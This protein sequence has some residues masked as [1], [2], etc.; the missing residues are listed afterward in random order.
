MLNIDLLSEK[1]HIKVISTMQKWENEKNVNISSYLSYVT[2]PTF[3]IYVSPYNKSMET[4]TQKKQK[5]FLRAL[6]HPIARENAH[7]RT[8]F[9][10]DTC[11]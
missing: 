5:T 1:L 10:K 3:F 6:L 8:D 9:S 7:L 2:L 4:H 11:H